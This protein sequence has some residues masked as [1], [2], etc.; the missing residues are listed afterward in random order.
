[1]LCDKTW[2]ILDLVVNYMYF[3]EMFI[4]RVTGGHYLNGR[5]VGTANFPPFPLGLHGPIRF[6]VTN[7]PPAVSLIV[8][9]Q[10]SMI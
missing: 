1:M 7:V 5:C 3:R 8:C 6:S 2:V 4:A 10:C 9:G